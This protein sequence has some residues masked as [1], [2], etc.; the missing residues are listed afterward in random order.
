MAPLA[1]VILFFP[2]VNCQSTIT[3]THV[4]TNVNARSLEP[5]K[6][7]EWIEAEF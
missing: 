3:S 1:I 4:Y 6:T 2:K 7:D 5:K